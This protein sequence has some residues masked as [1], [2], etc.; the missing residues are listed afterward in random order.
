MGHTRLLSWSVGS[1]LW[2]THVCSLGPWTPS[3][4]MDGHPSF[5]FSSSSTLNHGVLNEC[6]T[7]KKWLT[8]LIFHT[9]A[10]QYD[11]VLL[12]RSN[13]FIPNQAFVKN[14]RPNMIDIWYSIQEFNRF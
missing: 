13:F 12:C 1:I 6:V 5:Y 9:M 8:N 2:A 7:E 10:H 14:P 11:L 3:H 4:L